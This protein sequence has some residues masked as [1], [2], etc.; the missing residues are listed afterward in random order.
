LIVNLVAP[1][2]AVSKRGKNAV[3]SSSTTGKRGKKALPQHHQ[4]PAEGCT[5]QFKGK[6]PERVITLHLKTVEKNGRDFYT[7]I[8]VS[9]GKGES[10]YD[11]HMKEYAARA[12][13][14]GIFPGTVLSFTSQ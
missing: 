14:R 4:C 10:H 1:R 11:A 6:D 12:A 8:K 13:A 9:G 5:K 3:A 7:N 2:K